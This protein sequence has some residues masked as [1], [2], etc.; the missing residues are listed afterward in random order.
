MLEVFREDFGDSVVFRIG[1]DVGIEPVE[2]AGGASARRFTNDGLVGIKDGELSEELFGFAEGIGQG[3]NLV[4]ANRTRHRG[5]KLDD[6]LVR[7]THAVFGYAAA[8]QSGRTD[9]QED[10]CQ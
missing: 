8:E 2:A 3:K 4:T 6:C 5:N 7:K 9:R 10:W 1:P